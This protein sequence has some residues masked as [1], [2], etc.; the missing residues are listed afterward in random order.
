MALGERLIDGLVD[1]GLVHGV[2][3]R[4]RVRD[5]HAG[6]EAEVTLRLEDRSQILRRVDARVDAE[7]AL[8]GVERGQLVRAVAEH[9]HALRLQILQRQAEVEDGLRA[10]AHDHDRRLRQ[11]LQVGGD[12]HG[13]LGAAVHA[14]DAAGGKDGDARH[15]GDHHR[16]GDGGGAV[17]DDRQVAAGDLGDLAP[18]LAEVGDLLLGQAGLQAAAEDGDGGGHCTVVAQGLLD[19]QRR[20]DV[21]RIGHAVGDDRALERDDRAAVCERLLHLGCD[22]QIF[23][24]IHI[25]NLLVDSSDRF[26][27]YCKR[28]SGIVKHDPMRKTHKKETAEAVS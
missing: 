20:F 27:L 26:A 9:G 5:E 15:V 10:R 11:L 23:V 14:A 19:E 25:K 21:F 18:A 24:Q 12:V 17:R 1:D 28:F 4:D 7:A 22:V 2:L 3:L 6:L 13:R 16:R 8:A